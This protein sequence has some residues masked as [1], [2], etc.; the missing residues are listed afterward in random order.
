MTA[1][2]TPCG[3]ARAPC[4]PAL[5]A[6]MT[7]L[8]TAL[9]LDGSAWAGDFL[10]PD[11]V[12]VSKSAGLLVTQETL[13]S[14]QDKVGVTFS[15][16][17]PAGCNR[18]A[19]IVSIGDGT[20]EGSRRMLFMPVSCYPSC[21]WFER[22]IEDGRVYT[23]G[24]FDY[25]R[26]G[27]KSPRLIG[28]DW[29]RWLGAPQHVKG[30]YKEYPGALCYRLVES[31]PEGYSIATVN[32]FMHQKQEQEDSELW[33]SRLETFC[34]LIP[35]V[36]TAVTM[37][38]YP[39]WS[40]QVL[41]AA[42][43]DLATIIPGAVIVRGGTVSLKYVKGTLAA[44]ELGLGALNFKQAQNNQDA[45]IALL[46][47]AGGMLDAADAYR[48]AKIGPNLQRPAGPREARMYENLV[49]NPEKASLGIV[50]PS[51]GN[52]IEGA[53]D[54]LISAVRTA[55]NTPFTL[56]KR[57]PSTTDVRQYLQDYVA[58]LPDPLRANILGSDEWKYIQDAS[59]GKMAFVDPNYGPITGPGS[60]TK[61]NDNLG[62]ICTH[63]GGQNPVIYLNPNWPDELILINAFHESSH[64]WWFTSK[65]MRARDVL[66]I[67]RNAYNNFNVFFGLNREQFMRNETMAQIGGA[68]F[69][70]RLTDWGMNINK[71][72]V[73]GVVNILNEAYATGNRRFG[74]VQTLLWQNTKYGADTEARL[75]RL[76]NRIMDEVKDD[77][78]WPNGPANKADRFVLFDKSY[79]YDPVPKQPTPP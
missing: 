2:A 52:A 51:T 69:Q 36:N 43:G 32:Q 68:H 74:A 12:V 72:P 26:L 5:M 22:A 33:C 15:D 40:R 23:I 9:A 39:F 47:I 31:Y 73:P 35:G 29:C 67:E 27:G 11:G 79:Y 3:A 41:T 18:L 13:W 4:W 10:P 78:K 8:M 56:P 6:L 46:G 75:Q 61:F 1:P 55:T 48:V 70:L 76:F 71:T 25:A 7:A 19:I 24:Y 59:L 49:G 21:W 62:G 53:D 77:A 20:D 30:L 54:A 42:A 57:A 44:V 16:R 65:Q 34:S 14:L 63:T 17:T 37:T 58:A 64:A 38:D 50:N 45:L 28:A 60:T 66:K